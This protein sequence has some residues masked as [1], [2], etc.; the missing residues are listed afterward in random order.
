MN[1]TFKIVFI[2]DANTG[3]TSICQNIYNVAYLLAKQNGFN[4]IE[5]SAKTDHLRPLLT[6]VVT[7]IYEKVLKKEIPE[8]FFGSV[9]IRLD[10]RPI[11]ESSSYFGQ[12]C[13]IS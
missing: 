8:S 5:V 6:K 13:V 4:Y 12:C 11:V 2:G 1:Y 9:G 10:E 7:D 3:K